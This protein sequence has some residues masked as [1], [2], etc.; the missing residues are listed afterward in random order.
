M[1]AL[2]STAFFVV[3]LATPAA[4]QLGGFKTPS[5]NIFCIL[6]PPFEAGRGSDLRCDIMQ[7]QGRLPRPPRDCDLSWG[8]AFS[9]S[10]NGNFAERICHGDTA[11]ND[12]LMVLPYGTEWRR[13]PFTCRSETGGL[14]CRNVRQHGFTV[15]RSS[16][17]LF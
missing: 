3:V 6:E 9:I 14:T 8:D 17:R 13:G 15:S 1:K 16:Q 11:R 5:N 12:E 2:A 10:E 4:A 7:T